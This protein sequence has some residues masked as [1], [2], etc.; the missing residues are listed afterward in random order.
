M[1]RFILALSLLGALAPAGALGQSWAAWHDST[2]K[3][4]QHPARFHA[5]SIQLEQAARRLRGKALRRD[6]LLAY[7]L[8]YRFTSLIAFYPDSSG[9]AERYIV[10]ADSLWRAHVGPNDPRRLAVT[11]AR[12]RYLIR[13]GRVR[14]A[15]SLLTLNHHRFLAGGHGALSLFCDNLLAL[16]MGR[17]QL[18]Q[19]ARLEEAQRWLKEAIAR[20]ERVPGHRVS[21]ILGMQVNC[22]A[23]M[24]VNPTSSRLQRH[25]A[26]S[27]C[28]VVLR[29][30]E[31]LNLPALARI[32]LGTA[33]D[34]ARLNAEY[35]KARSL[36]ARAAQLYQ[37]S[38]ETYMYALSRL[39]ETGMAQMQG[40]HREAARNYEALLPYFEKD[41]RGT[42][43]LH[44]N[45]GHSW[46]YLDEFDRAEAYI[47]RAQALFEAWLGSAENAFSVKTLTALGLIAKS[48][49]RF[50]EASRYYEQAMTLSRRI[51]KD[52]PTIREAEMNYGGLLSTL[53]DYDGAVAIFREARR[54]LQSLQDTENNLFYANLVSGETD[55]LWKADRMDECFALTD[56]MMH[57]Y[58][59]IP[60]ELFT[61]YQGLVETALWAYT[62]AGRLA[63]ADS[64]EAW[65]RQQPFTSEDSLSSLETLALR[66]M[67]QNRPAEAI[68][69]INQIYAS[70]SIRQYVWALPDFQI[71]GALA[72]AQVSL[73][74]R[75]EARRTFRFMLD[76]LLLK[77]QQLLWLMPEDQRQLFWPASRFEQT[78]SLLL[79]NFRP[80][81]EETALAYDFALNQKGL[82]RNVTR[83]IAELLN[84]TPDSTTRA[85]LR[86]WQATRESL[87]RLTMDAEP[88]AVTDSVAREAARL[89]KALVFVLEPIRP[90]VEKSVGWQRVQQALKP[91]EAAVELLRFH[92]LNRRS[93]A[94]TDTLRYVALVLK[95]GSAPPQLLPLPDG[96]LLE[97]TYLTDY[98]RRVLPDSS[99]RQLPADLDAV[100]YNRYWKPLAPAL[101]GFTTVYLVPDGVYHQ[102][103]LPTLF[104]PVSKKY[105]GEELRLVLLNSSRELLPAPATPTGR[106]AVLLGHP[107]YRAKRRDIAALPQTG[108]LPNALTMMRGDSL[109]DLPETKI[110]VDELARQLARHGIVSTVHT[111]S[112]ASEPALKALHQPR[113]L[114]LATHGFFK[115]SLSR[116]PLLQAGLALAGAAD[117]SD[118]ALF[119]EDGLLTAYEAQ[120]L[121]LT[122][123][124][125]VTL[126]ACETGRG[127]VRG[128]E[129]VYGLQRA[130]A[131]AGAQA[132]LMSLW[133]VS[134]RV[135]QEFMGE[136]YRN[137]LSGKSKSDALR[138]TQQ[139]VRRAH[140]EPFYWGAFVLVGK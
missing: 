105:L 26:D 90:P 19:P 32:A 83:R 60:P 86:Q 4:L 113:L 41:V 107:A 47:R 64:I 59:R 44:L 54:R 69:F 77:S 79:H 78:Y 135:T 95:P 25:E 39:S 87:A 45:L 102:V 29:R 127:Q 63:E 17:V 139:A 106:D 7:S 109:I 30:A 14:Q 101:K 53:G 37:A 71:H 42:A 24:V 130:F 88:P 46:Y 50:H 48:R 134:D 38:G 128:G 97:T 20:Y 131:L 136:F 8:L 51:E 9:Y 66:R 75:D 98:L 16:S 52:G 118:H 6:T 43:F 110:E 28:Q 34:A 99:S 91:G 72:E 114:H 80:T 74:N 82:H 120:H 85:N 117:T 27:L 132:V 123:T 58:R 31:A 126:S 1:K 125:L 15:D 21:T 104:N 108:S 62:G 10:E 116:E 61:I 140:P 119:G 33:A 137:W 93:R 68:G 122:G 124:E 11:T 55:A 84:A 112:A 5:A 81:P 73:G 2:T 22:A 36:Y 3:Y 70:P 65:Y 12:G 56:S 92:P 23:L 13:L 57:N 103:S 100:S 121:D 76:S 18:V 129:G 67:M 49:F 115:P 89:E 133:K 111:D 35:A 40:A 96:T 94:L 138:L